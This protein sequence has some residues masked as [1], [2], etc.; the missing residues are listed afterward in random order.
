MPAVR[1]AVTSDGI[2]SRSP[3]TLIKGPCRAVSWFTG[4]L[5]FVLYFTPL[6][7]TLIT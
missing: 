5:Y 6:I 4:F 2:C 3:V 1:N 7:L